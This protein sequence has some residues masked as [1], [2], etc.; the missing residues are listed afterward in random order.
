MKG[1]E[2][3]RGQG[4]AYL[5]VNLLSALAVARNAANEI[6]V[7]R[8][9]DGGVR[10]G[11]RRRRQWWLANLINVR[12]C[13]DICDEARRSYRSALSNWRCIDLAMEIANHRYC[14]GTDGSSRD[15]IVV[16]ENEVV[17]VAAV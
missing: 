2:W 15:T 7:A 14:G 6:K 3:R 11:G 8:L 4:S 17:M 13:T 9:F 12:R 16:V 5:D 1:K 10:Y